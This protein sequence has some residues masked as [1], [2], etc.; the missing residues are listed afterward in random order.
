[1]IH[2]QSVLFIIVQSQV[3]IGCP[4]ITVTV[5]FP[6]FLIGSLDSKKIFIIEIK[7]NK[8]DRIDKNFF[9]WPPF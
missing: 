5:V 9:I 7:T 6:L 1:M 3:G 4:I 2:E 8:T